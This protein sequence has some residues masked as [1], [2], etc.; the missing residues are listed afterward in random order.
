MQELSVCAFLR[1]PILCAVCRVGFSLCRG[2]ACPARAMRPIAF[3]A[4]IPNPAA[5]SAGG[6]R[7]LLFAFGVRR[8]GAVPARQP[9]VRLRAA[10]CDNFG[11]MALLKW[12]SFAADIVTMIGIVGLWIT[13]RQLYRAYKKSRE[14]KA[15]SQDC[16][17][18]SERRTGINLVPLEKIAAFPRPSDIVYL[19]GETREGTN[20]GRGEYEVERVAFTFHEAPEIDQPCPAVPSKVIAY[21][22]R[23]ARP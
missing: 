7:D 21:V 13:A 23:R 19:P 3:Y 4:V 2:G 8:L 16:L 14:V 10:S 17:E 5:L 22:R 9:N 18:F 11:R 1:V 15:V 12:F 20:Y 6:V